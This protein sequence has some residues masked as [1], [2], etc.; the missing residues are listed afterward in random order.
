MKTRLIVG[1]ALLALA[2]GAVVWWNMTFVRVPAKVWVGPSGEARLRQFLAAERFAASCS[3]SSSVWL[4]SSSTPR[5][6]T[7]SE[8]APR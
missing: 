6:C 4:A 7:R 1:G 3:A 2:I 5:R 8:R